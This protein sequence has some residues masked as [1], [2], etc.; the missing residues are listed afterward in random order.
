VQE[1][2]R[3]MT[4]LRRPMPGAAKGTGSIDRRARENTGQQTLQVGL[5]FFGFGKEK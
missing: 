5:L 3:A 4:M 1:K 2:D